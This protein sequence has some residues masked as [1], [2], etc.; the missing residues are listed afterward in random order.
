MTRYRRFIAL[1]VLAASSLWYVTCS[2]ASVTVGQTA[3]DFPLH[4]LSG[5]QI[6]LSQ[7]RG[8][9][10]MLNLWATWCGPCRLEFPA[11]ESLYRSRHN[12]GLALL[13][14]DVDTY[15]EDATPFLRDHPVTFP[16]ALDPEGHAGARFTID[17]MPLTVL[18]DRRGVVRWIH[19]GYSSGDEKE[20]AERI[21]QLLRG[22]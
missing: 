12:D 19:R 13:G 1:T 6:T 8:Q 2:W 17:G 11:L 4:L 5:G 10:V 3:P 16:I 15:S 18:I 21:D 20:Y 7:L 14:I 22:T 9:V